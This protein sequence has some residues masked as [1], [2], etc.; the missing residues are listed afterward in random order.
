MDKFTSFFSNNKTNEN[1]IEN[2]IIYDE[3]FYD[4]NSD[5]YDMILNFKSFEQLWNGGWTANFTLEGYQKYLDS[6]QEQQE[7]IVIGVVGIKNR[8][9]S[10]L[11]KRIMGNKNYKPKDGFLETTHG[12][13]CSF[14]ILEKNNKSY[15]SF[16]TLDTAG[17]DNP[18][19]QNAYIK[20]NVKDMKSTIRDQKVCEILLSDFIIRESNVL[21][22]VVEQLSFAEQEMLRTLIGRLSQKEVD[23]IEKRKLIVIH[24]LMNIK[25][26]NDIKNFIDEILKKSLTF[27]LEEQY[28]EDPENK[29]YNLYIYNQTM[30]N[31][32]ESCD[33]NKLDIVHLVI[34]NDECE[35][36]KKKYNEPA[37]KYIRDYIKI[38]SFRHFNILESFK[39]FIIDNSKKFMSND[40][41]KEDSLEIGEK[42]TKKVYIDKNREKPPED[43]IIIPIKLKDN[44]N[45]KDFNIKPFYFGSDGIYYFSNGI[46]PLY[47]TRLI[48]DQNKEYLEITFEMFGIVKIEQTKID[49]NDKQIIIEIKGNNKD[50]NILE[51]EEEIENPQGSLKYLDFN[52][53]IKIDR[54]IELNKFEIEIN[55]NEK[56]KYDHNNEIYGIY[57]LLFPI[58]RYQI[59]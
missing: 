53:Q 44:I 19:L 7:N 48:T 36:I 13:S 18:L 17:K 59:N 22:A 30:A 55:E 56:I 16:I 15:Q 40:W 54:Y 34:G 5:N 26:E 6:F 50:I 4:G 25:E 45:K 3:I 12:I 31:N 49:Y 33:D 29:D 57:V 51:I 46:E 32:E 11:L 39:R 10:F 23:N 24:N 1:L 9:K 8:G 52:F 28:V 27:A 35:V 14:P 20:N 47:S 41:F 21:I 2:E 38:D 43:K 37:F 42:K 58:K